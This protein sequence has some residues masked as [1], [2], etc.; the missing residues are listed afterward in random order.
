MLRNKFKEHSN[1]EA[2]RYVDIVATFTA[3]VYLW[4]ML[5]CSLLGLHIACSYC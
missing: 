3:L 1:N 2:A 4:E 5:C